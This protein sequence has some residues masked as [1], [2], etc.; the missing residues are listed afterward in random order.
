MC[1]KRHSATAAGGPDICPAPGDFLQVHVPPAS[2]EPSRNNVHRAALG[3]GGRIDR[4]K[5]GS[6]RDDV[7][8]AGKASRLAQG[9]ASEAQRR[10]P[11]VELAPFLTHVMRAI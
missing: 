3:S 8:H 4:E 11:L 9:I 2:D 7:S 6:E 5:L 1:G 10:S